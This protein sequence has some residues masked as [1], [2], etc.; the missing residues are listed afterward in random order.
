MPVAVIRG[1]DLLRQRLPCCAAITQTMSGAPW[2]AGHRTFSE[3]KEFAPFW[4]VVAP[5]VAVGF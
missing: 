1:E 2:H 3:W 4:K 5:D